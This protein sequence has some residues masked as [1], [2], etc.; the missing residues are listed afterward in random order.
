MDLPYASDFEA[1]ARSVL[2]F[3]RRRLGFDLWMVTR[4]EGDNWIVLASEGHGYGVKPGGVFRWADSFCS[5]MVKG[6]GPRIAPQSELV[7]AYA[8]API[9]REFKIRAYI[10]LPLVQSNGELF[11]TLCAIDPS[12]KPDS[13]VEEQELLELLA[14]MLSAILQ[15]ELQSEEQSRLAERLRAESLT[16]PLTMLYNRRGWVDLLTT[17]ERRCRRFGHSAAVV[18]ADLD[19]LKLVNDTNGHAAGDALIVRTA[20]ALRQAVRS[21]DVVSRLGGDEFGILSVHCDCLG[22]EAL[23]QRVR[24]ALTEAGVAASFG[25]SVRNPS[26][27]LKDAWNEADRRMYEEKRARRDQAELLAAETSQSPRRP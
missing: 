19:G 17:E 11:G 7:P 8:T 21:V 24:Q 5:E 9:G 10:G 25:I 16:D 1:N 27:G 4:T 23:S 12:P 3:L 14:A 20:E 18:I 22:A 6:N 26:S 2:A 13:L 15:S